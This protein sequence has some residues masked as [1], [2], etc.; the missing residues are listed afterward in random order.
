MCR[1]VFDKLKKAHN[2]YELLMNDSGHVDSDTD[3][4]TPFQ[5]DAFG[6]AEDYASNTFGQAMNNNEVEADNLPPLMEVSDD[7]DNDEEDDEEE[8]LE[9]VAMVAELEKSWEPPC[10]GAPCQDAPVADDDAPPL[11]TKTMMKRTTRKRRLLISKWTTQ[12]LITTKATHNTNAML[13]ALLSEM[14]MESS[15]L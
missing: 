5:G 3:A 10:E 11:M 12:T 4:A 13:I 15:L 6:T 2:A 14:A 8:E 1:A 9:M 7:E